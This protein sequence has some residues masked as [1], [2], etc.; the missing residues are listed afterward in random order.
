MKTSEKA[1]W[2]RVSRALVQ[3]AGGCVARLEAL[4][5]RGGVVDFVAKRVD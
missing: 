3:V 2:R 4:L 5:G 1:P